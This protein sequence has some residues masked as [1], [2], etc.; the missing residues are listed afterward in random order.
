MG[1]SSDRIAKNTMLLYGRTIIMMVLAIYTSRVMLSVLG[2]ENFGIYNVVGG[3]VAM[4][5][6]IKSVLASSVQRFL[7]YYKG[8]G[9]ENNVNGIFS[10][11]L[12]VHLAL[13]IVFGVAIEGFGLWFIPNK[14]MLPSGN[15]PVAM[16]VFHC[17][18]V[19]TIVTILTIPHDAA[20]IAN[21]EMGFYAYL[22]LSES[23]LKLLAIFLLPFLPF[24][25]L[26]SYAV[27][28]LVVTIGLRFTAVM[29]CQRFNECKWRAVCDITRLKEMSSFASWNF[30]GCTASSLVE[31]G[32]NFVLN[33]FGGVVAN[34]ARGISYQVK[35]AI[36]L[37]SSNVVI[38]S[39][40]YIMQKA[41]SV[42]RKEFFSFIHTQSRIVFCLTMVA[43]LPVYIYS[44]EILS[45]WLKVVPDYTGDFLRAILIYMAVM[46]FQK[47]IDIAFKSFGDIAKYQV[48][49]TIVTIM[50]LPIAYLTLRLGAPIYAVFYVFSIVRLVDYIIILFL[51]QRKL[52]LSIWQYIKHVVYPCLFM[53][54]A[55]IPSGFIISKCFPVGGWR[56]ILPCMVL[57]LLCLIFGYLLLLEKREKAVAVAYIQKLFKR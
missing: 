12:I 40:P 10:T 50:T 28:I 57:V 33:A 38:A 30:L 16:F 19:A 48:I 5:S 46:S 3:V 11:S 32:S 55:S 25:Y 18:V 49:D 35:S 42:E 20:V 2:V 6:S 54:A 23:V 52:G 51:A 56:I 22:S 45:I 15:L 41:P 21:E 14:L 8:L 24:E 9:K 39:Q 1:K 34:A 36:S 4:F 17:S 37:L 7:N 43:I 44:D 26:R 29:Y 31:E 13:A 53:T 47:S 27:L